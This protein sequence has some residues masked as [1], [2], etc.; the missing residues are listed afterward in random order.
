MVATLVA[1]SATCAGAQ[2]RRTSDTSLPDPGSANL[3]CRV[4]LP[5]GAPAGRSIKVTLNNGTAPIATL[6]SDEK[7][8]VIFRYLRAGRY[9]VDVEADAKRYEPVSEDTDIYPGKDGIVSVYLREKNIGEVRP[10]GTVTSVNELETAIPPSAKKEYERGT[11]LAKKGDA[12]GAIRSFERAVA[13]Y[14]DYQKARNDLG[15]QYFKTGRKQAAA[16]QFTIAIRLDPKAYNPKLNM[17]LLLVDRGE[18]TPAIEE[19]T[20][21]IALDDSQ[22]AAHLHLGIALTETG[23]LQAAKKEFQTSLLLGQDAFAVSYY[24]LG[25]VLARLGERNDALLALD[26]YI[27]K[28]PKGEFVAA[29]KALSK[30]LRGQ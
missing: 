29:A 18:Y 16:E 23:E 11:K 7:G 28:Q 14:G 2:S 9:S 5:S 30:E 3:R 21:A 13:L 12:H 25:V 8:E 1:V 22:P 10:A 26:S 6:S 19:L 24:R 20:R 27:R 4:L 17:G 15:V